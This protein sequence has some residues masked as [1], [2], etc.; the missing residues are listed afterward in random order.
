V[1]CRSVRKF[2]QWY[3]DTIGFWDGDALITRTRN[4]QAWTQHTTWEFSYSFESVEIVTP[5]HDASEIL[6]STGRP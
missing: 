2:R 3:G 5:V 4:V 6:A 1:T